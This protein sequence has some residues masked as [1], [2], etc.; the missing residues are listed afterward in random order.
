[1]TGGAG[2]VAGQVVR[3]L[4]A[5]G[6]AV[7]VL[8]DLSTGHRDA[9][10]PTCELVVGRIGDRTLTD[11]L[12]ARP[13]LAAVFHFAGRTSVPES[14]ADP[15]A[16]YATNVAQSV[17][18][19]AAVVERRPD[20][21]FIFSSSAG[22]YGPPTRVPVAEDEALRPI[23][24]YGETKRVVEGLLAWA[25]R[26]HGLPWMALRYFNAAGAAPGVVER[27]EPEGHLIPNLLRAAR[28]RQP[29]ALYG[30]DYPTADGTAVRDY[31]HILDLADGHLRALA[32]LQGGG[33]SAPVNL[34]SGRGASVREVLEAAQ[35]VVG[36][37]VPHVWQGRR[38]GDP[39]ALVADIGRARR[40]LGYSPRH[41][42]IGRIVADAW[43][44][45]LAFP[46]RGKSVP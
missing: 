9:L 22:V 2:F 11:A 41:S 8:D 15:I 5:R 12:V 34:G 1:V 42:D 36:A 6:Y 21:P 39:P 23:S 35:A 16:Y 17:A 38:S 24:P 31:V 44:H 27:H 43:R 10:P 25:G 30:T 4:L 45:G 46:V 7:T 32:H 19:V 26:A 37:P 40:L 14:V 13:G 3:D 33:E 20:V 18:L 29:V 28:T